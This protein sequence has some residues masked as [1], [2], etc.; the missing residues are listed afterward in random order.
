MLPRQ[1]VVHE[2]GLLQGRLGFNR[3]IALVE[4]GIEAFSNID[5]VQQIRFERGNIRSTFGDVLAT[6]KREFGNNR[7]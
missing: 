1:N 2:A 4:D 3:A 6:L 5:G 7:A